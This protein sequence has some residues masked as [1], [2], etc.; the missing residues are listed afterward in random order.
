MSKRQLF[1]LLSLTIIFSSYALS[2][3]AANTKGAT[4]LTLG[5]GYELF[6]EKRHMD[7]TGLLIGALDYN[8]SRNWGV[9]GLLG[10]FSAEFKSHH[11]YVYDHDH[12]NGTLFLVDGMYHFTCDPVIQPY[13]LAGIGVTGIHHNETAANNEG[14]INAGLG[15]QYFVNPI[16]ALRA[17]ARDL[18]TMTGGKNDILFTAGVSFLIGGCPQSRCSTL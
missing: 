17:D 8:F 2:T 1:S 6:A 15:A 7:D 18:Y 12:H 11:D 10:G 4:T 13:L 9:E 16:V 3:Y 14:N 5:G